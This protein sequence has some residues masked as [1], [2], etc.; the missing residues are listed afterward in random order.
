MAIQ[1]AGLNAPNGARQ[2]MKSPSTR[3]PPWPDGARER[4]RSA[5][6][7]S[8]TVRKHSTCRQRPA[9][10]A[11]IA[12]TTE[13]LCPGVSPAPLIQVGRSR[14]DSSRAVTPPSEWPPAAGPPG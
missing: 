4:R 14:R 7:D 2:A 13:P 6:V 5:H 11:S 1:L 3:P 9:A 10:T 8:H 12:A